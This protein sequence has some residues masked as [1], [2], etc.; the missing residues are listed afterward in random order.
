MKLLA[1]TFLT[2]DSLNTPLKEVC[3]T[4][5]KSLRAGSNLIS[6]TK[7]YVSVNSVTVD[8][9][10]AQTINWS[11]TTSHPTPW[12]SYTYKSNN[13]NVTIR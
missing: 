3:S 8:G 1:P 2:S 6:V 7:V 11:A 10:C 12:E 5:Y 4:T 13:T 9:N